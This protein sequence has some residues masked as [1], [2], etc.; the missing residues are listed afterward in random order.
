MNTPY[1][2][3]IGLPH[4]VSKRH[5]PMSLADRA[6]Q[7]AP[8]AALTGY[9]DAVLETARVTDRKLE[10]TEDELRVLDEAL[11][12]L[13]PL[14]PQRPSVTFVYFKPDARK[15][16]GAYLTRTGI[17]KKIDDYGRRI[18]LED[19]SIIPMDDLAEIGFP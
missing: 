18:L 4:P 8:F 16:G 1:D 10:L 11:K 2:D 15:D 13:R 12:E 7:F 14:L 3:I 5:R 19:G 9:G 6:A 17:V